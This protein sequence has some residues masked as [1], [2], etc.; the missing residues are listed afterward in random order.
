MIRKACDDN[1]ESVGEYYLTGSTSRNIDTPHTGTGRITQMEMFPMTLFETGESNGSVSIS[2]IL[3]DS[4]Y[5]F[6]G[7]VSNLSLEELFYSACRG[8]WPRCLALRSKEGKLEIARD[9]Y[10]QIISKDI[11]AYDGVKRNPEW[12]RVLLWSY[13]RN[14]ATTAKK[15]RIYADVRAS[16]DVT[17][18]TL[19]SY[20]DVLERLYVKS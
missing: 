4:S 6:S 8:G 9:Y 15:N 16:F 13:A 5:D 17:D 14:M 3:S 19:A 12:A 11:S 7:A 1:P 2:R 20:I 18:V 10:R